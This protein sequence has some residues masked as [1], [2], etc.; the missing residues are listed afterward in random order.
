MRNRHLAIA[1]SA[2][3]PDL[4]LDWPL[5]QQALARHHIEAKTVIWTDPAVEWDRYDLVLASGAWDNTRRPQEFLEW[6]D[7]VAARTMLQNA[8]TVL[9]WNIDQRYLSELH[10]HG[11]PTVPTVWVGPTDGYI[12][13][14]E[15]EF[16]IKPTI[17]GG[18]FESARYGP[19]ELDTARA[20]LGRL[21][22]SGRTAMV[23]PYITKVDE[24][25][26][27]ALIF[28][29]SEFSHAVSKGALL[30]SGAGVQTNLY[31]QEVITAAQPT[32]TYLALAQ[33]AL[34]VAEGLLGPTT[35]AR[36]DLIPL[37]DGSPAILELELLDPALFF[38]TNEAMADRFAEVL[39]HRIP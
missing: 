37:H 5:L 25:G 35:Y 9:R 26:E 20:H 36:V 23:Q 12:P 18:G 3:H 14:P 39:H 27:M 4:R 32:D 28:L 31:E 38:E 15:G 2:E 13:L 17:S 29:G 10:D 7:R 1:A 24:L 19:D 33:S 34:A 8:P 11:L 21:A 6:A 30:R 16:V 22:A